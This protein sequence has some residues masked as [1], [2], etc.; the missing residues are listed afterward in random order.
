MDQKEALN[1]IFKILKKVQV[2]LMEPG[3]CMVQDF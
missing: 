2:N 3:R 1:S